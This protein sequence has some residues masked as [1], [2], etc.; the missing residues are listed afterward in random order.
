MDKKFEDKKVYIVFVPE[1]MTD[2]L[3]PLDVSVNRPFQQFYGD[4][5]NAWMGEAFDNPA[6]HTKAGNLKIPSYRQVATW[7]HD[8]SE[9]FMISQSLIALPFAGLAIISRWIYV[10]MNCKSY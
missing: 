4:K 7:C 1:N 6:Q 8:F 10:I 3:Q 2:I 5:F 9:Q